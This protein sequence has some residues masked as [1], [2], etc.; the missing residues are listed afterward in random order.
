MTESVGYLNP[1]HTL[2]NPFP[3]FLARFEVWHVFR[4]QL[5]RVSGFGIAANPGRAVM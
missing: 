5:N 3:H 4:G 2:I 1:V